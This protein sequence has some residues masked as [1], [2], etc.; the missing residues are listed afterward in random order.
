MPRLPSDLNQLP[1]ALD[2]FVSGVR[3]LEGISLEEWGLPGP[4]P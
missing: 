4:T 2:K 3:A 1:P